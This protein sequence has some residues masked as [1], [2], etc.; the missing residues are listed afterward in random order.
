MIGPIGRTPYDLH[1]SLFGIPVRIHPYFWAVGVILGWGTIELGLEF[2]L[3]W[4]ACLF[5]SILIHELG[6]AF[7]AEYF[8]WPA[9]ITLYHFGGLASFQPVRGWTP[10]RSILISISGPGAGFLFYAIIRVISGTVFK[11]GYPND[12]VYFIFLQLEWINL[13]WGLV[14]LIPV[15]PLDGG[16]VA[17]EVCFLLKLQDPMVAAIKVGIVVSAGAAYYFFMND[18]QYAGFMFALLCLSNFQMLQQGGR[19]Y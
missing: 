18:L 14:N 2:M 8:G 19:G 11:E 7:A 17:R 6:H 10:Q 9:N 13:Y 1:F 3:A 5:F 12:M 4:L 15:M 16:Q